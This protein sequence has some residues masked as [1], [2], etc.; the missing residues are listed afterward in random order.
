MKSTFKNRIF[1]FGEV[2]YHRRIRVKKAKLT[3]KG[4]LCGK[5]LT[6]WR[7]EWLGGSKKDY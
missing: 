2:N 4:M 6:E 5:I 3:G 1:R 7:R